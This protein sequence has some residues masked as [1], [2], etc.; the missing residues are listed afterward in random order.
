[1]PVGSYNVKS[2][3]GRVLTPSLGGGILSILSERGVPLR[4]V[5]VAASCHD[6]CFV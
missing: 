5:N 4:E 1:V 2:K 6:A 3:R